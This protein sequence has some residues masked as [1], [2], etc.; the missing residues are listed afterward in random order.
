LASPDPAETHSLIQYLKFKVTLK[1]LLL[2]RHAKS[3]WDNLSLADFDRPLN[4][5]G[6]KSAPEM[7]QRLIEKKIAIDAFVSSPAKRAKKTAILFADEYGIDKKKIILVP[8]LYEAN[9]EDFYSAIMNADEK[10]NTIAVFSH[11]PGITEFA[12]LLTE[13]RIDNIPTCGVFGVTLDGSWKKI[14][15]AKKKFLF[16]DYPKNGE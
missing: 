12:N 6:K 10:F 16:F 3:D 7:A 15:S 2:V 13:A 8:E 4:E 1:T 9:S 5:R 11:N 14:K